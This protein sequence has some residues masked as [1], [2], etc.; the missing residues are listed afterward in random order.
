MTQFFLFESHEEKEAPI[1]SIDDC[2]NIPCDMTIASVFPQKDTEESLA[3]GDISDNMP[4]EE[5]SKYNYLFMDSVDKY[6][7]KM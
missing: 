1:V 6:I 7:T 5:S 2:R 3:M 4:F